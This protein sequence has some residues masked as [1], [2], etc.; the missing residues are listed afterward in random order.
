MFEQVTEADPDLFV[1]LFC[2]ASSVSIFG[3]L[4]IHDSWSIN[5][6][7]TRLFLIISGM[8]LSHQH[9]NS[10][11]HFEDPA[12]CEATLREILTALDKSVHLRLQQNVH[13]MEYGTMSRCFMFIHGH[14]G[15]CGLVHQ[16][17]WWITTQTSQI[18]VFLSCRNSSH[19]A[20]IWSICLDELPRQGCTSTWHGA[21]PALSNVRVPVVYTSRCV[22]FCQI[23][24]DCTTMLVTS[25][26]TSR[27][28]K[29][30]P[31]QS[32]TTC[33]RGAKQRW[34]SKY[35][36]SWVLKQCWSSCDMHLALS[37]AGI[38]WKDRNVSNVAVLPKVPK[39][40]RRHVFLNMHECIWMWWSWHTTVPV[41]S[42][43]NPAYHISYTSAL[44][45]NILIT[46]TA[47][48][49]IFCRSTCS[50]IFKGPGFTCSSDRLG[51]GKLGFSHGFDAQLLKAS[52]IRGVRGSVGLG[53]IETTGQRTL[54]VEKLLISKLDF[55][56]KLQEKPSGLSAVGFCVDDSILFSGEVGRQKLC[57]EL[58]KNLNKLDLHALN[59]IYFSL[60]LW[61]HCFQCL[62]ILDSPCLSISSLYSSMSFA[63]QLHCSERRISPWRC[64]SEVSLMQA[65][66]GLMMSDNG[67]CRYRLPRS[68]K[69]GCMPY[70]T[71]F[72]IFANACSNLT[73]KGK[74]GERIFFHYSDACAIWGLI[75]VPFLKLYVCGSQPTPFFTGRS[76]EPHAAFKLGTPSWRLTSFK[77]IRLSM[78][79]DR[80]MFGP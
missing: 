7:A 63:L 79:M 65:F 15:S 13:P 74:K 24:Q 31:G 25:C 69:G 45:L 47:L 5:P 37:G 9:L 34:V 60:F 27:T 29:R 78:V 64:G 62:Y 22:I 33:C 61:R 77:G 58:G 76:C 36:Q 44:F 57:L 46:A 42:T 71:R 41:N 16:V 56:R 52:S 50:W 75:I 12:A 49:R 80:L 1:Q 59:D 32:M 18:Y 38:S 3:C 11:W 19:Q 48:F 68:S 8:S 40:A 35:L 53:F 72:A 70:L 14:P 67:I 21:H 54:P 55:S 23:V 20:S 73:L 10:A 51:L 28:I 6:I 17:T 43:K 2:W 66:C 39:W 4:F 26:N 30:L